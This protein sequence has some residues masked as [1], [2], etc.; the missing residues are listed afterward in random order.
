MDFRSSCMARIRTLLEEYGSTNGLH[1]PIGAINSTLGYI[2]PSG[3]VS[4]N[5][6][7]I[8]LM[9]GALT[10][11][12][13]Y[14]HWLLNGRSIPIYLEHNAS[15]CIGVVSGYREQLMEQLERLHGATVS[16]VHMSDTVSTVRIRF[17]GGTLE[18][19]MASLVQLRQII[20]DMVLSGRAYGSTIPNVSYMLEEGSHGTS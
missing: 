15:V 14:N 7:L 5:N 16:I 6:R 19:V 8:Y 17:Q 2:G 4:N 18:G 13:S 10:E 11:P 20:S 3:G 9:V 1:L 12:A